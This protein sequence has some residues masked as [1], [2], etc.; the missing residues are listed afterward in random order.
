MTIS[1]SRL[2]KWFVLLTCISS[3]AGCLE[4]LP[5]G[6]LVDEVIVPLP[7]DAKLMVSYRVRVS[8]PSFEAS[9]INAYGSAHQK[10]W[11]DWGPAN[12]GNVYMTPD[13]RVVVIGSGGFV[14]M[15][16][17]HDGEAPKAIEEVWP[18]KEDGRDWNYLGTF[19]LSDDGD[20]VFAPPNVMREHIDLLGADST[21]YRL[22]A[23]VP[24]N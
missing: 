14:F 19:I 8:M 20:L 10:L 7:N 12:R 21:P 18:P 24:Q 11:E 23:Q 13:D 9:A 6:R 5:G 3:L 4:A 17:M 15:F 22:A 1:T 2:R 16:E